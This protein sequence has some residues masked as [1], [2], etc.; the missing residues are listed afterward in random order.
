MTPPPKTD[1]AH[2]S[3]NSSVQHS[4]HDSARECVFVPYAFCRWLACGGG[5]GGARVDGGKRMTATAA[6][7]LHPRTICPLRTPAHTQRG[8]G[9]IRQ[10][11]RD[12][13]HTHTASPAAHLRLPLA[14]RFPVHPF[15]LEPHSGP[16]PHAPSLADVVAAWAAF[17]RLPGMHQLQAE[18]RAGSRAF[19]T[20]LSCTDC[21]D[22]KK[23]CD[24][25]T[26]ICSTCES[27]KVGAVTTLHVTR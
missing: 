16:H 5:G 10:S 20:P 2:N 13:T 23:K 3:H 6:Q 19:A 26:P 24:G 14:L 22:R 25:R 18:V 4:P 7:P 11:D 17:K 15:P 9:D 12:S 1:Y 8:P 21:C 27:Y